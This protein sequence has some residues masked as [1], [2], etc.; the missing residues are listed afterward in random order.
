MKYNPRIEEEWPR[1]LPGVHPCPRPQQ[2]GC[3]EGW[4]REA[5]PL[6]DLR[7]GRHDLPARRRATVSQRRDDHP[8]VYTPGRQ[9]PHQN[10]RARLRP[11]HQPPTGPCGPEVVNRPPRRLCGY[12]KLRRAGPENRDD[13][14]QPNTVGL[15]DQTFGRSPLSRSRRLCYYDGANLNALGA[16]PA[17]EWALTYQMNL[18]KP[19]PTPRRRRT[20]RVPLLQGV[21]APT[22]PIPLDGGPGHLQSELRGNFLVWCGRDLTFDPGA[23]GIP[24]RAKRR[25]H[26]TYLMKPSPVL[27]PP[28]MTGCACTNLCWI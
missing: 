28:P 6:R 1:S 20:A 12:E 13:A 18:H 25:S 4:T 26:A 16:W 15:F 8:A 24:E 21:I 7:H 27:L 23:E 3:Q 17:R 10:H 9:G 5:V 22:F 14:D 11:R 2:G 19:L